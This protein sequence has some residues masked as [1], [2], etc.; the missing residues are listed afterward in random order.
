[1][2]AINEETYWNDELCRYEEVPRFVYP[3]EIELLKI[4]PEAK[5]IIPQKIDEWTRVK[6]ELLSEEVIPALKKIGAIKDDFS[7]WFWRE[8]YKSL[9]NPRF[10]EAVEQSARLERLK[11]LTADTKHSKNIVNFARKKEVAKQTPILSLYSFQK[12]RKLGSRYAALCPFHNEGTPSFVI[13]PDNSFYCFGCQAH[14]DAIDFIELIK[15]CSFKEA[16]GQMAGVA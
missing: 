16:I 9:V 4:F 11:I 10:I 3:T 13:Y 2:V 12:L 7:R 1:M 8:A 15:G 14:G 6:G 5:E